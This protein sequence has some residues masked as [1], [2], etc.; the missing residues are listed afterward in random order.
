MPK[1]A[2]SYVRFSTA[3]QARGDSLRRQ[4]DL[5][6]AYALQ[7]GFTL[8][9]SL[10]PD[11]GI[12]AFKGKNRT[13]GNLAAFLARVKDGTVP[14]DSAL[15]VESLDRLSREEVEEALYFFLDIVRSGIEIHT[16]SDN[17]VY[18]RGHLKPE[19]LM[20]SLFIMA[21]ANEESMRKSDRC[22][23][24]WTNKRYH[25]DGKSAMSARVP[26]WLKAEK[27]KPIEIRP[28]RVKIVRQ[29]VDWAS[30]GIG[31]YAIADKLIRSKV[32]AWGP[33]RNGRTPRWTSAYVRDILASRAVLGE[34]Q[35]MAKR[36]VDGKKRRIPDGPL[37][38]DYYPQV[39]PTSL[40]Q[41]VQDACRA[42]AK[43]RFGEDLHA[44]RN[45]YSNKNLF[46]KL[47]WDTQNNAP[48][49]YRQY[50]GYPHLVTT[51]RP[52]L[53]SHK[54]PYPL[55]EDVMLNFLSSAD[56]REIHREERVDAEANIRREELAK[57]LDDALKVR[58]RYEALLDDADADIGEDIAAKYKASSREVKRLQEACRALDAEISTRRFGSELISGTDGIEIIC[59]D[60]SP[61]QSRTK[62]RLFLAQRIERIELT[63]RAEVLSLPDPNRHV[64][65][66]RPGEGHILAQV[67][68]VNGA[69]KRVFID[70]K[71]AAVLDVGPFKPL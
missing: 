36:L 30:Q 38:P 67:K 9:E 21:R 54:I 26:A 50:E 12:S 71:K 25:A 63:F 34:Y 52:N 69:E 37:A 62:L 57:Q 11:K 29:I 31:Q 66:I 45:K 49:V 3:E 70:G 53:R 44:G 18:R 24:A 20:L 43:V 23:A 2:Y 59:T 65:G 58:S 61:D 8:D 39:I 5:S 28:E 64:A 16:L 42:F 48:M 32:P 60:R 51:H 22:R 1:T 35:P 68:F 47:V 13:E 6:K 40:W 15:L 33:T 56:W 27:G 41:K 4:P 14:P 17:Q 19:Q 55:F 46:R 7:N 10:K